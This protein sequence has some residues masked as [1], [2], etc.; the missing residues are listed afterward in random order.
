MTR[1]VP[2]YRMKKQIILG[3][4]VAV[5]IV[6]ISLFWYRS[7]SYVDNIVYTTRSGRDVEVMSY[8]GACHFVTITDHAGS[9]L[10]WA[11]GPI[12]S[13][14]ENGFERVWNTY[15]P[16]PMTELHFLGFGYVRGWYNPSYEKNGM[17]RMPYS[18]V[19]IPYWVLIAGF[20]ALG[21]MIVIRK[22]KQDVEQGLAPY[23]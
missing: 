10:R 9:G 13:E 5:V 2:Q 1:S 14:V 7:V 22:Q 15:Y 4:S 18:A 23:C 11:R 20:T 16:A 12:K 21:I 6:V 17:P 3:S 19:M 8:L